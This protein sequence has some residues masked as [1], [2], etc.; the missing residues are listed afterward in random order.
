[1]VKG[2]DLSHWNKG[3]AS[4]HNFISNEAEFVIIKSSEGKNFVDPY[5][6]DWIKMCDIANIPVY[7]LYHFCRPDICTVESEFANFCTR[8]DWLRNLHSNREV[9]IALDWEGKALQC[10]ISYL[11]NFVRLLHERYGAYPLI[12]I[13]KSA[14]KKFTFY[15]YI[16]KSC[17]LWIADYKGDNQTAPWKLRAMRQVTNSPFDKDEFY[18]D[19]EQLRKYAIAPEK[20]DESYE[21]N[22][23]CCKQR[24][25]CEGKCS[26]KENG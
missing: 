4:V 24:E 16:T 10:D 26:L 12:Y 6:Q 17:G 1:M 14:L 18:G 5:Y 2:C 11:E 15:N 25:G 9:V 23:C 19:I 22:C 3:M 21:C 20:N 7:G 8:I 13:Q